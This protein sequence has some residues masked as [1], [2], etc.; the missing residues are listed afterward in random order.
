M[1]NRAAILSSIAN[2]ANRARWPQFSGLPLERPRARVS[3]KI[4]Q[5]D[6]MPFV[7]VVRRKSVAPR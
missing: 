3:V 5:A 7:A 4:F 1:K 2:L 6:P